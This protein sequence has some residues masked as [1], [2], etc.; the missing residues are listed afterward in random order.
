MN[1]KKLLFTIVLLLV[2]IS[3]GLVVFKVAQKSVSNEARVDERGKLDGE[4]A[5]PSVSAPQGTPRLTGLDSDG[6]TIPDNMEI[7]YGT[8]PFNPDTDNDGLSDWDERAF[9]KTDPL[10]PD[11]DGDGFTD[12]QEA[13]AGYDPRFA[14]AEPLE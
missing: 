6:D 5:T 13:D 3:A 2:I 7:G 4:T 12:G 9:W 10:N 14:S 1:V 8:D 11:T